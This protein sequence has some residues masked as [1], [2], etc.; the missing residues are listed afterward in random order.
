M[1]QQLLA[2]REAPEADRIVG[3]GREGFEGGVALGGVSGQQ[4]LGRVQGQQAAIGGR[5][6]VGRAAPLDRLERLVREEGLDPAGPTWVDLAPSTVAIVR[7]LPA[8][9]EGS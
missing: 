5:A 1:H 3:E 7:P 4:G 6:H 8:S 9:V 2:R